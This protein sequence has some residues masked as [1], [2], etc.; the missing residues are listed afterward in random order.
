[1]SEH[2]TKVDGLMQ[3]LYGKEGHRHA[4]EVIRQLFNIHNEVFPQTLEYST[5]CSGCRARVYER[6]KNWWLEHGGK[7]NG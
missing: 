5:S 6:V 1:M 7:A 4:P 3:N 2:F